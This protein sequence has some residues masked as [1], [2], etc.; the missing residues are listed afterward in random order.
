MSIIGIIVI[1]IFFKIEDDNI[2]KIVLIKD[3]IIIIKEVESNISNEVIIIYF[4]LNMLRINNN[5]A[6]MI[7][8]D[9]NK[10]LWIIKKIRINKIGN[11]IFIRS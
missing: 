6:D 7:N 3:K 11:V 9:M 2:I 8:R 5:I 1:A 10:F 4:E